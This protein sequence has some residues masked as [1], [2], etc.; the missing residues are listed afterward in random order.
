[1][2]FTRIEPERVTPVVFVETTKCT[3]LSPR[4]VPVDTTIQF[5]SDVGVQTHASCSGPP[6]VYGSL[7]W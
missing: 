3:G 2:S 7:D 5:E 4:V 6:H 1:L